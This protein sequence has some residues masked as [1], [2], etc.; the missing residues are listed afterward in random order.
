VRRAWCEACD[1]S[2]AFS[3]FLYVE[4]N[5]RYH[6]LQFNSQEVG[7][8]VRV[9]EGIYRGLHPDF[10]EHFTQQLTVNVDQKMYLL[11]LSL[12]LF[13]FFCFFFWFFSG[14]SLTQHT[15]TASSTLLHTKSS[16]SSVHLNVS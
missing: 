6:L 16:A 2:L 1:A 14:P 11:S 12:S 5:V 7:Q 15:P 9:I 8:I 13:L 10:P 4:L 3:H